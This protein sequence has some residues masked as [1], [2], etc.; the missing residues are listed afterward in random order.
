MACPLVGHPSHTLT[1]EGGHG[2]GPRS[3]CDC[4]MSK[5]S[6]SATYQQQ[7][8]GQQLRCQQHMT[9]DRGHRPGQDLPT[10][11]RDAACGRAGPLPSS[12]WWLLWGRGR[13][14]KDNA[15]CR[16]AQYCRRSEDRKLSEGKT[17]HMGQK[18]GI[19]RQ[20][21]PRFH[22]V[23]VRMKPKRDCSTSCYCWPALRARTAIAAFRSPV[24]A[25][26]VARWGRQHRDL[27]PNTPA[28]TAGAARPNRLS[29]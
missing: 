4:S 7:H 6:G 8:L 9:A 15:G 11:V 13:G 17:R 26:L 27:R 19:R 18:N 12:G 2:D 24:S 20:T 25:R 21:G 16:N 10:A 23:I 14:C 28:G 29:M 1:C 3:R 5:W 22:P